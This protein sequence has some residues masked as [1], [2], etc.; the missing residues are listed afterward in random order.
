MDRRIW[1]QN[2]DK[3]RLNVD[4]S[5][6]STK[7]LFSILIPSLFNRYE[8]FNELINKLEKQ[9]EE[10]N[11]KEEIEIIT[12][13]DNKNI[14][15]IRKRNN[16]LLS[17]RGKFIAFLDDDDTVSDD[18]IKEIVKKI[19]ENPESD[20]ITFKQH[21]N[22]DGWEFNLFSDINSKVDKVKVSNNSY[23]RYPWIWCVWKRENVV[24]ISFKDSR[25]RINCG[26]DKEWLIQIMKSKKIKTE[27]KIDKVLHY[28][29]F[30]SNKTETQK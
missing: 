23:I 14:R 7:I 9:I 10:N 28:Y 30:D 13:I 20:V 21:C 16:M 26:E 5:E 6:E 27:T 15:L 29:R 24:D 8:V 11:L 18:Y 25:D 19:K 1:I 17:S 2:L 3:N 4:K 12:H 22:C